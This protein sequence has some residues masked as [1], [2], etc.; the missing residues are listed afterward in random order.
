MV[1][2]LYVKSKIIRTPPDLTRKAFNLLSKV[3]SGGGKIA[4][5]IRGTAKAIED[6]DAK[7]VYIVRD[8]EFPEQVLHLKELCEKKEIPYVCVPRYLRYGVEH[9]VA[10]IDYGRAGRGFN[11]F[12]LE[13]NTRMRLI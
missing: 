8:L 12:V 2:D 6:G 11:R 10:I 1:V 13:L 5:T 9:S 3:K 4:K 7:L